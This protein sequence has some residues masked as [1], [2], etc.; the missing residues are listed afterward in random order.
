MAFIGWLGRYL[1]V[2]VFLVAVA[3]AGI[4]VGKKMSDNKS[5]KEAE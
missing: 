4:V 2:F 5:K 3:G 1:L